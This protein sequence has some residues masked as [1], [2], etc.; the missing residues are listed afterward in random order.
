M[1]T[2]EKMIVSRV[3]KDEHKRIKRKAEAAGMTISSYVRSILLHSVD[4]AVVVIDTNPLKEALWELKKQGVNLNQF[5]RF[6]NTYGPKGF[7]P[8][9]AERM[10]D[11][12]AEAFW[13]VLDALSA[14][15]EEAA[16]ENIFI[17]KGSDKEAE[18]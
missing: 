16:R 1:A 2:K 3:M 4:G 7:D 11:R 12:E 9:E 17:A 6:L 13:K 15:R 18:S 14:L 8:K 10:M 5:M